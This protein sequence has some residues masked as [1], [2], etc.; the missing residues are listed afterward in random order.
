MLKLLLSA[1]SAIVSVLLTTPALAAYVPPPAVSAIGG[2]TGGG[3][4]IPY[5]SFDAIFVGIAG[6][7]VPLV[8][9]VAGLVIARAA[10]LLIAEQSEG[11]LSKFKTSIVSA[12]IAIVLVS[13]AEP[14]SNAL[15]GT[16]NLIANPDAASNLIAAEL[17][18]IVNLIEEPIAIL[19][20]I[21][22]VVSGIRTVLDYGSSDGVAN[23][24]RTIISVLIGIF[25]IVTKEAFKTS[26]VGNNI[27]DVKS[28]DAIINR[29]IDILNIILGYVTIIAVA[30]IIFAGFLMI[31][32]I[33]KDEQYT[34]AK[35]IIIRVA[36]G[37][38][39]ILTAA[40]IANVFLV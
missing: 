38:I 19:A 9:G 29:I 30:V 8:Y 12:I 21:M 31:V 14:I 34:R 26:I 39:V 10:L 40:A 18:G 16:S 15:F 4:P 25:F 6:A 36:I 13:I 3:L 20:I 22:I 24:R 27:S 33:G 1:G 32:N 7:F 17:L 37:L 23:L 11:E 28:P 35:D 5:A 2:A